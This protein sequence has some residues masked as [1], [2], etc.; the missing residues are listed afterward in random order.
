MAAGQMSKSIWKSRAFSSLAF[1][2]FREY[3]ATMT[4]ESKYFASALRVADKIKTLVMD[5]YTK[6]FEKEEKDDKTLVTQAD[7]EAEMVLRDFISQ[8]YP[9]HGVIGEEFPNTN[10][11][12]EYQWVIDPIDGTQNFANY[13]P[14]FGTILSLYHRDSA[15]LGV[16]DHPALGLRYQATR[17]GGVFCNGKRISIKDNGQELGRNEIIG[18]ATR[19]MFARTGDENIF[20]QLVRFHESHRIYFDVYATTLAISGS[21]AAMIEYNCTLWDISCTE[22]MIKEAGGDYSVL[23]TVPRDA[24]PPRISAVYG[25]PSVVKQIRAF[26]E[27]QG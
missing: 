9:D 4:S 18:L 15:I 10:P 23:K 24:L 22:L 2:V 3:I 16:I 20:D 11:D 8:E 27:S 14:T 1:N 13:V 26:I 21:M 5:Y 17:G 6:G 7:R 19:G 25:R 12:A